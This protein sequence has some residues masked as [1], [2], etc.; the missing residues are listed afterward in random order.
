MKEP[1]FGH[2]VLEFENSVNTIRNNWG[3]LYVMFGEFSSL[4]MQNERT[5][6]EDDVMMSLSSGIDVV[7]GNL[8]DLYKG[9]DILQS[10]FNS[11]RCFN[12]DCV[13]C[14]S[15]MKCKELDCLQLDEM[16]VEAAEKINAEFFRL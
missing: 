13:R 4:S 8:F 12:S 2:N 1:I 15:F 3:C 11:G 6:E 7:I 10:C 9:F 14:Y 16:T 5:T